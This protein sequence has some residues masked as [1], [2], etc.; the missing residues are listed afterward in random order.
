MRPIIGGDHCIRIF[1][2]LKELQFSVQISNS[3]I[4]GTE[5]FKE[6]V[7]DIFCFTALFDRF[8]PYIPKKDSDRKN[9][10]ST[11][12]WA[13]TSKKRKFTIINFKY[14]S[15]TGPFVSDKSLYIFIRKGWT[16]HIRF[17]IP[18]QHTT[19]TVLCAKQIPF[20]Q[21]N[22]LSLVQFKYKVKYISYK[23]SS[24]Y[25]VLSVPVNDSVVSI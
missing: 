25:D 1:E 15:N 9:D 20:D 16:R 24:I 4:S 14:F 5:P 6:K 13:E 2:N 7:W 18:K 8:W 21:F 22:L 17:V 11:P 12:R 23:I 19:H 3:H 10:F